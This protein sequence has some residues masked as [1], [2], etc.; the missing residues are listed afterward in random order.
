MTRFLTAARA[1][2]RLSLAVVV[3]LAAVAP[4]VSAQP[5]TYTFAGTVGGEL[6][7]VPVPAIPLSLVITGGDASNVDPTLFGPTTAG[8]TGLLGTLF[9]NGIPAAT[10]LDPVY[11]FADRATGLVGW[12]TTLNGDVGAVFNAALLG[13]D[14]R[15]AIGPIPDPVPFFAGGVD[16]RTSSGLVTITSAGETTFTASI[17]AVPE[18]GTWVLLATGL[19]TIAGAAWRR[20]LA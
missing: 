20:R 11:L 14:L 18:P 16:V 19:V 3:A 7:G 2:R 9:M 15:T 17:A 10:L 6:N 12:G 4:S 8:T 1:A 13:Y 5:I